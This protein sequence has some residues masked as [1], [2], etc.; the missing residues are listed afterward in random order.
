MTEQATAASAEQAGSVA[1][2]AVAANAAAAP[3]VAEAPAPAA[4]VVADNAAS[5]DWKEL[6]PEDIRGHQSLANYQTLEGLVKSHINLEKMLGSEKVPVPKEGDQDGWSRYFK[7]AGLPDNPDG[8]AFAKPEALPEGFQYDE[9]LDKRLAGMMHK[10]NLLP[11]QAKPLREELMKMVA[12]GVTENVNATKQQQAAR[13]VEIQRATEA[14]KQE[15][16]PTFEQRGKVAG[17][18][19]NKFLSPETI[20]AMDAVGLANNPAIVKDMYNLGVKLA[21]EKEL[22]GVVET[23]QAPRDLDAAIADHRLKHGEALNDRSHPDH[24]VRLKELTNLFNQRFG[25]A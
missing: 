10:A 2:A 8:Y 6:L 20:A 16:G 21:G 11:G 12:E 17:A 13:E 3:V 14:L 22:I 5:K 19:I 1:E 25:S 15:W 4:A 7:A 9:A 24:S 23:S 18:A